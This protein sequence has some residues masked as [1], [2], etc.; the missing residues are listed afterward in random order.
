MKN[1]IRC[2]ADEKVSN[3]DEEISDEELENL[4]D[5]QDDSSYVPG[6]DEDEEVIFPVEE[7][8]DDE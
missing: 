3:G 2:Q 4:E 7:N 5:P 1:Y 8:E 6:D